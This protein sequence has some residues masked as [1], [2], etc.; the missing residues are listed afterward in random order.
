M[1]GAQKTSSA[2]RS[3]V[4]PTLGIVVSLSLNVGLATHLLYRKAADPIAVAPAEDSQPAGAQPAFV[5]PTTSETP[6]VT[7]TDTPSFHW[8][9]IESTD[10][11]QYIA[12][13]RGIGVPEQVIRDI[14]VTDVNQ[15]YTKRAR[16]IWQ[17]PS[18]KY[19]Q[20][21]SNER[22]DPKQLDQLASLGKEHAALLQ[23]L[24]GAR[25]GRQDLIDTLYLQVQGSERQ[26]LFL[27]PEKRAA[28]L[29]ALAEADFETKEMKFHSQNS[30]STKDEQKLFNEKLAAL[31]GVLSPEELDEFH[32]RN[33]PAGTMLKSELRYFQLTPEEY[34][35]LLLAKEAKPGEQQTKELVKSLLGEERAREFELVSSSFYINARTGAEAE[36]IPLDR[37]EQ[38]ARFANDSMTS[39][40]AA[41][42]DKTLSVEARKA[43]LQELQA[44]AESK[45]KG[46][47][48]D[49]A[50]QTVL[51]DLR[52]VLRSSASFIKP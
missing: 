44:E 48:G 15:L 14:I 7:G 24:L 39:G 3:S 31:A 5:A 45:I 40:L 37:V 38:A 4:W 42:Q 25:I 30:Y 21:Y 50:S 12:N 27:P 13:L 19:W 35:Q 18:N 41:A 16:E 43:R 46:L 47:L 29:A 10:Y 17:P 33:S 52:N 49:K 32:R 6:E 51:R 8:S 28:A 22:P 34:Q 36:G 9:E 2:R 23:E 26:M 1:S 11:R 20:K